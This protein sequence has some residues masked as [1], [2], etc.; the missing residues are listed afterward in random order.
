MLFV[1]DVVDARLEVQD[2]LQRNLRNP[3]RAPALENLAELA[4]ASSLV[5]AE[6]PT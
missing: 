5:R 1:P 2:L 6:R 4:D 3:R